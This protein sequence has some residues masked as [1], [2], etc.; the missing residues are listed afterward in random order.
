MDISMGDWLDT[1]DEDLLDLMAECS[2]DIINMFKGANPSQLRAATSI[3]GP[4]QINAVAGSGKTFVLTRRI[5][6]MRYKGIKPQNIFC[7]TFTKKA[8]GEMLE[9]LGKLVPKMFIQQMTLGTT[10]S[11]GYKILSKEYKAMN[12]PLA[13]AFDRG[14][15]ILMGGP[16]KIFVEK[17][18]TDIMKDMSIPYEVKAELNDIAAL[19]LMKAIANSKNEGMDHIAY[20][21][22]HGSSNSNK[23]LA[24]VEFYKRYEESKYQKR[25]ID[26]DD[27]LFLLWKLLREEPEILAKYRRIYKYFLVD[28][29]QDN[30]D[31]QY[32]LITMLAYPENN[33]FVVGDDDQCLPSGTQVSTP[34]GPVSIESLK[35]GDVVYGACGNGKLREEYITQMK[36]T[37]RNR[38]VNIVT[39]NGYSV[40]ATPG[41][42]MMVDPGALEN[43]W[44]IY[45]MWN[46]EFGF[47]IGITK[48]GIG[49]RSLNQKGD[50]VWIIDEAD[51]IEEALYKEEAY[52][53]RYQI[54]KIT[55]N[56]AGMGPQNTLKVFSE[57][58]KC[59]YDLL[60]D[61]N[62]LVEMP[63]YTTQATTRAGR[64]QVNVNVLMSGVKGS[65][66][67][68]ETENQ[69][70]IVAIEAA[71]FPMT[72]ANGGKGK[73][74]RPFRKSY[75]DIA[76]MAELIE[77]A[78][79]KCEVPYQ[80]TYK[81]GLI[82]GRSKVIMMP[83]AGIFVGMYLPCEVDGNIVLDRV[84][85]VSR[86]EEIENVYDLEVD[87][88]HNFIANGIVVHNS[89][90][91]FRGA[92]PT[93]FIYFSKRFKMAKMVSLE[94]NYRSNPGILL[95][96]NKLIAHNTER[97][98][99]TLKANKKSVEDAVAYTRYGTE[100][101]EAAKVVE[102]IK[103]LVQ[104]EKFMSEYKQATI[105]YR[106][107]A[108]SRALEDKLIIEGLP[109]VI[110]GGVSFYERK[111]VKDI[112][113]YLSLVT[114]PDDFEAF[115]RIYNTPK[116]YLGKVF[117]EKVRSYRGN[118][119][120]A[121][122]DPIFRKKLTYE[123]KGVEALDSLLTN[124]RGTAAAGG[125]TEELIDI[126][127]HQGGY[128][129][130]LNEESEDQ[131]DSTRMENIETLKYVVQRH[132]NLE[133]F[134]SY[135]HTMSS[136]AKHDVNGVQLMTIH[137][138]KG[139][140]FP[141]AFI[142]GV[143]EGSLPHFRAVEAVES[144]EKPLAVEEERRLMYVA[145][146]RPEA[147][148]YI[149]STKSFNQRDCKPSRFIAEMGLG[150]K[151]EGEQ[152]DVGSTVRDFMKNQALEEMFYKELDFID[153]EALMGNDVGDK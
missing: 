26:G 18:K 19:Q 93:N 70:A 118:A 56:T 145:T 153:Q 143:N 72:I 47:R 54:T 27:L 85:S 35:I 13:A 149:S 138:S 59:G 57:F 6:Y 86:T 111:E 97:I 152:A 53:L 66:L 39:E 65:Q 146:T 64:T 82:E 31:L 44:H 129:A 25:I 107:N 55:Y 112:V 34:K 110:H 22:E 99:K 2:P 92:K 51:T 142:V 113:A 109:Y 131:E 108:Q 101:E 73:R 125:T 3:E 41:H 105:L 14:K 61:L 87:N 137:K 74:L 122:T 15:D 128:E 30:N 119:V 78:L 77:L 115:S 63:H 23:M 89:M 139:L 140:E 123:K 102:E 121:M 81:A 28:E 141:V 67:N 103:N 68:I 43:R 116:R 29:T 58:G 100:D 5:A 71:G 1:L 9:R 62:Y 96:A 32:E 130:Y 17:L 126:I 147:R 4:V 48:V 50:K 40:R 49:I 84:V 98:K 127:L 33:I 21:N 148:C 80:M 16:H 114:D 46:S 24:Y 150:K 37:V 135:I 106:T 83:A 45:L 11:I 120:E 136:S 60:D 7:T 124:L 75:K 8:T 94:D 42:L 104:V 133:G 95:V 79:D 38:F 117:L 36:S 76:K 91:G 52:S 132:P 144:G 90:Y 20:E 134:L 69:D 12:H 88:C 10:H 151:A